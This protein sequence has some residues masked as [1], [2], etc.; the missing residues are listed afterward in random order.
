ML[1]RE[2]P[3]EYVSGEFSYGSGDCLLDYIRR[4]WRTGVVGY[5]ELRLI[6]GRA[7]SVIG[8]CG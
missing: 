4:L 1:S 5:V 8:P 3:L 6:F 7:L 2:F